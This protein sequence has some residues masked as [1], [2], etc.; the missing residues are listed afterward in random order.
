MH[1]GDTIRIPRDRIT[2]WRVML[3]EEMY[4]PERS[5]ALLEAID[6]LRGIA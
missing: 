2:D 3:P 4:G 1:A 5:A 6:R